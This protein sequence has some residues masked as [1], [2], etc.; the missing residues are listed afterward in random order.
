M[1]R[2]LQIVVSLLILLA[3]VGCSRHSFESDLKLAEQRVGLGDAR[4]ALKIY[5]DIARRYPNNS[6]LPG[7]L[8]RIADVH[9]VMLRDDEEAIKAYGVVIDAY[10]LSEASMLARERRA[11]IYGRRGDYDGVV[12]DYS[13]LLGLFPDHADRYRYR[14]LMA[15]GYMSMRNFDLARTEL[16]SLID[17]KFVP[18]RI[19]AQAIFAMA[20]SYFLDGKPKRA[21]KYYKILLAKYPNFELR[22]EAMLHMATCMEE[23][24][25]LG[26]ARELMV[27]S[28]KDFDNEQVVE[29]KLKGINERGTKRMDK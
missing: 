23:M 3:A 13:A 19:R 2:S 29:T 7:I 16:M 8:F 17:D 11:E 10:P 15:S 12:A 18:Q 28:R 24:G 6:K 1:F 9:G 26:R 20:E 5:S 25:K 22:G 14:I 27:R 4:G 21:V